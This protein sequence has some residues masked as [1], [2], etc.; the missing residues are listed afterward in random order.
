MKKI[1]SL[2]EI[3]APYEQKPT[4]ISFN[5]SFNVSIYMPVMLLIEHR[6]T[7]SSPFTFGSRPQRIN[8]KTVR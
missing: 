4:N 3:T 1:V 2:H 8:L 5:V 6:N 7:W